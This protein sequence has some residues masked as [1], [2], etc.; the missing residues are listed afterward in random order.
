MNILIWF[1]KFNITVIVI[2]AFYKF[3]LSKD[4]FFYFKRFFL[5][6]IF[7]LSILLPLFNI[8][9]INNFV[10]EKNIFYVQSIDI[11]NNNNNNGLVVEKDSSKHYI[12]NIL[13]YCKKIYCIITIVLLINIFI[14]II[15]ILKIIKKGKFE[16]F[17]N[18]TI[19][20]INGIKSPF[21]F[22]KFMVLDKALHSK[23]EIEEIIIHEKVH[24]QQWHTIDIIIS[25][26]FCA[27]F[28][29]NPFIWLI[30]KEIKINLEFIADKKVVNSNIDITNYQ[31]HLLRL[32]EYKSISKFTNNFN[33]SPLK[34]RITMMN[35]SKTN[36]KAILKY[37]L[38]LPLFALL[39]GS[40]NLLQADNKNLLTINSVLKETENQP[41]VEDT[42]KKQENFNRPQWTVPPEFPGNKDYLTFVKEHVKY[43]EEAKKDS[44]QGRVF[45]KVVFD[46]TGK[47]TLVEL[48]RPVHPLLDSE[49]IRVVKLMPDWI[50]AKDADGNN[51][52]GEMILP[53]YFRLDASK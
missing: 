33:I 42:I 34:K 15:S 9:K 30:K 14:Q 10:D 20:N 53:F 7:V 32:S 40:Y 22:F 24:I 29:I 44:I 50:P 11:Q 6:L 1:I 43:P 47:I 2:F 46:K 31:Y 52:G 48:A 3:F 17:K 41:I 37:A 35:K 5:L 38:L 19:Y 4:T 45:V 13:Q 51:I 21:S 36:R 25:E 12:L 8:N 18:Y 27:I 23:T 28:W 26:I 49:A 39:L 16:K